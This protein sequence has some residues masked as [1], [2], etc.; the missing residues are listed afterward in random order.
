MSSPLEIKTLDLSDLRPGKLHL[1]APLVAGA[2]RL[3]DYDEEKPFV[4]LVVETEGNEGLKP[5]RVTIRRDDGERFQIQ[6]SK[7]S[8]SAL[9]E[10]IG[11]VVLHSAGKNLWLVYPEVEVTDSN[12]LAEFAQHIAYRSVIKQKKA[13]ADTTPH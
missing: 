8:R 2:I 5:Y 13:D 6:D 11:E 3:N 9:S 1:R 12:V 7:S 10:P 4:Q